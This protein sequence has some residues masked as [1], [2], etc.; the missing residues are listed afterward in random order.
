M[1]A[2]ERAGIFC[3][4]AKPEPLRPRTHAPTHAQRLHAHLHARIRADARHA[5]IRRPCT[6]GGSPTRPPG[7]PARTAPPHARR[8][9][10]GYRAGGVDGAIGEPSDST[11][12][13]AALWVQLK[14]ALGSFKGAANGVGGIFAAQNLGKLDCV[15]RAE[16]SLLRSM[17]PSLEEWSAAVDGVR[18][19]AGPDG[20]GAQQRHTRALHPAPGEPLSI[21]HPG[22]ADEAAPAASRLPRSS[23]NR[24]T[25]FFSG[26][27]RRRS[28]SLANVLL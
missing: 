8:P 4:C 27:R 7:A 19:A 17:V 24:N 11:L 25:R 13:M 21:W 5:R 26:V 12:E 2:T 28:T 10:S 6:H 14:L 23:R 9:C 1:R 3:S 20:G 15:Q 18:R 16:C 22:V